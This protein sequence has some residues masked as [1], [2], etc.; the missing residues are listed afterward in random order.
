M[1]I[2]SY[3]QK[4]QVAVSAFNTNTCIYDKQLK[5]MKRFLYNTIFKSYKT[6]KLIQISYNI[7]VSLSNVEGYIMVHV[8]T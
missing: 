3:L 2:Y 1:R 4:G 5:C 8:T 6:C 7:L